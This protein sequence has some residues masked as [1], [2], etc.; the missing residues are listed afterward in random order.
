MKILEI[1]ITEDSNGFDYSKKLKIFN[2]IREKIG[3]YKLKVTY[4]DL[5]GKLIETKEEDLNQI[6]VEF[7]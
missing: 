3:G 5:Y 7:R 1:S 6:N 2:E 4:T